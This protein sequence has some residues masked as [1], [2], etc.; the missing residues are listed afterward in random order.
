MFVY[1]PWQNKNKDSDNIDN[2]SR[3]LNLESDKP[4]EF[5]AT[6]YNPLK[7]DIVIDGLELISSNHNEIMTFKEKYLL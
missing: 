1:A 3:Y 7:I 2:Q 5:L 4:I 6:L